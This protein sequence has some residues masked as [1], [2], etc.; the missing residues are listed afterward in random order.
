MSQEV[1][2]KKMA[3][4]R[5]IT[6]VCGQLLALVMMYEYGFFRFEEKS[7]FFHLNIAFAGVAVYCFIY[8][9]M[10]IRVLKKLARA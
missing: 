3:I 8:M 9:M 6:M 2:A 7:E 10:Q 1:S 5:L 4:V